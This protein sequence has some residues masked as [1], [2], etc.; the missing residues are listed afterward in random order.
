MAW[1]GSSVVGF[2]I[3]VSLSA[4]VSSG[5]SGDIST[6]GELQAP[7]KSAKKSSSAALGHKGAKSDIDIVT[8]ESGAKG[9]QNL[10]SSDDDVNDTDQLRRRYTKPKGNRKSAA[11]RVK[12]SN[13]RAISNRR[14]VSSADFRH[15]EI[16]KFAPALS[17][18]EEAL[19]DLKIR[20]P[21]RPNESREHLIRE[22]HRKKKIAKQTKRRA[23]REKNP[24]K[25][26]E[27][28]RL[29]KAIEYYAEDVK[30]RIPT[31]EQAA[32]I[33][34]L[35]E[36][37]KKKSREI[38]LEQT[39]DWER[40]MRSA[41]SLRI[42]LRNKSNKVVYLD[43]TRTRRYPDWQ[44]YIAG[45][46][47]Y[48]SWRADDVS[49]TCKDKERRTT[50]SWHREEQFRGPFNQHSLMTLDPYEE[51]EF[52]WSDYFQRTVRTEPYSIDG[53][54]Y[55]SCVEEISFDKPQKAIIKIKWSHTTEKNREPCGVSRRRR[56]GTP[57]MIE[58]EFVIDRQSD[59]P[60]TIYLDI[61][62]NGL[63]VGASASSD[64][65]S[66]GVARCGDKFVC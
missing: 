40:R 46:E 44:F 29:A 41:V 35:R 14:T 38:S 65:G 45:K 26:A 63:S 18:L 64:E 6:H 28:I 22:F 16:P 48:E 1:L 12:Q 25:K 27:L 57:A 32:R 3:L 11:H 21:I 23:R 37:E 8:V 61:P 9:V 36:K 5:D 10:R 47:V 56:L 52:M 30:G 31:S 49:P 20:T 43:H 17:S 4:C 24:K 7:S 33:N 15:K 62:A 59:T 19:N 54:E 42:I 60:T 66:Q 50:F 2:L 58:K 55:R 13:N 34:E 39:R 51:S 53:R